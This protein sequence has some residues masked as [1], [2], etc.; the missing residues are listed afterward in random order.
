MT[1]AG[2]Y[3]TTSSVATAINSFTPY[4]GPETNSTATNEI[5][6]MAGQ[7]A[8]AGLMKGASKYFT[9]SNPT[10]SNGCAPNRYV[11]L[12]TDGLPT[13]D[14]AGKSWP[15]PGTTSANAYGMTV[16]FNGDGSLNTAGTNDQAVIDT[17]NQLATM[18][19][20]GVKTY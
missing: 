15:P 12:L 3:P 18:A 14:L 10:S 13:L 1:T 4:L 8:L 6:A 5:K 17:I 7:S 16:A 19:S 20:S 9:T 11:V 2:Q